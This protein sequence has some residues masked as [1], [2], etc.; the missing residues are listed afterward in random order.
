[1]SRQLTVRNEAPSDHAD[2]R[3]IN[4][5]TF[6]GPDEADLVDALRTN[7]PDALSL[8]ATDE[9]TTVGHILFSPVTLITEDGE[10]PGVGLAPMSVVPERQREGIGTQLVEAGLHELRSHG[11]SFVVVLGHPDYYPRFGFT[12]TAQFGIRSEFPGIPDD[13]F[14]ILSLESDASFKPGT[15]RYHS[16]FDAFK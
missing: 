3:R 9:G 15:I 14:M 11:V 7:C 1:M 5:V 8:V 12:P 4:R 16:A 6:D 10:S 13:V 2:I